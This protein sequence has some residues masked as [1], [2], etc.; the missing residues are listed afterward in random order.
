MNTPTLSCLTLLALATG[1]RGSSTQPTSD[2]GPTVSSSAPSASAAPAEPLSPLDQFHAYQETMSAQA[3]AGHYADVC[4]GTPW[5]PSWMCQWV[6]ARAD[7]K[8]VDRPD[9][10]AF[11]GFFYKEHWK[12]A[13]GTIIGD[14]NTQGDYEASVSGYRNHVVLDTVDT[15]YESNG[16]FD[17]WVQEEPETQEVTLKSGGTANWVV[18]DEMPLAKALMDLAHSGVSVESTAIAKDAM[19]LIASYAPYSVLK[20]DIPTPTGA[21]ASAGAKPTTPPPA[22]PSGGTAPTQ[23]APDMA[24]CCDALEQAMA[25]ASDAQRGVYS[26]LVG[27]CRLNNSMT[28]NS[29]AAA[30]KAQLRQNAAAMNLPPLP[31][32]CQ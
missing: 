25:S 5:F 26:A 11:R 4:K 8:G 15:K 3:E 12:H 13:Y 14:A 18:I 6:A 28:V 20:G 2:A 30:R 23:A 21:A 31:A 24:P 1:C 29:P 7:G 19:K 32:A 22:V 17:L 9:G 16:R 27:A 10:E